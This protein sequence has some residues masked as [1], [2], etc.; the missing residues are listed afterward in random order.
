MS[1]RPICPPCPRPVPGPLTASPYLLFRLRI[2]S[3]ALPEGEVSQQE[4][5]VEGDWPVLGQSPSVSRLEGC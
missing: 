4:P 3:S 5:S 1:F 2:G